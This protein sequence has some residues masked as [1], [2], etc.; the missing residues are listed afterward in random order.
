M[1]EEKSRV[2]GE[3]TRSGNSPVLPTVNPQADK[4]SSSLAASIHPVFYVM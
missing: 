2:S 1:S 4:S 3:V